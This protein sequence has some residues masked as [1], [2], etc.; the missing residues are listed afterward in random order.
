MASTQF[1]ALACK[2]CRANLQRKLKRKCTRELPACS[3]CVRL[4]K[5]CE[6]PL[7]PHRDDSSS[8]GSKTLA[9]RIQYL[10]QKFVQQEHAPTSNTQE[11]D[12]SFAGT[13]SATSNLPIPPWTSWAPPS[14]SRAFPE[15]YIL[16]S[17][18]FSKN[19]PEAL[20][21]GMPLPPDVV[22]TL[23]SSG[24]QKICDEYFSG[25]HSW[26]PV[27]IKKRINHQLQ[28]FD[29]S[30][31]ASLALLLLCMKLVAD[32]PLEAEKPSATPTYLL[33]REFWK[34]LENASVITLHLLQSVVLIALY[35]MGHGIFPAGY[36]TVGHA[37]RIGILMGLHDRR[38]A[39]QLF[40]QS[41]TWTLR[42][43]ERRT[44][45]AVIILDRFVHLGTS[46][47]PLATPEP[48]QGDL[49][50]CSDEGWME[51]EVGSNHPLFSSTFSANLD[52]GHFASTCQ[53]SH[54]LGRVLKHRDDASN[55]RDRPFR[56]SEAKQLHRTLVALDSDLVQRYFGTGFSLLNG[57]TGAVFE[58][59][60]L[61]CSARLIL[62]DM[63]G[64]NEP[65]QTASQQARLPEDTEMQQIALDG[66]KEIVT[67]RM[68]FLSQPLIMRT[69]LASPLVCHSLYHSASECAWFI[70]EN[71]ASDMISAMKTYVDLL[72]EI[73]KRWMIARH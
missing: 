38:N 34:A 50:P 39:A 26:L 25:T 43:E 72:M 33:A 35:E 29:S 59:F 27:L 69:D 51:G 48:G 68:S 28:S 22:D 42:E 32:G 47:L 14:R 31:N 10:E 12:V 17:D 49:L 18:S 24:I 45:W 44:W 41:E 56:L 62:Y 13:T 40:I 1:A 6:Y 61:C 73:G 9:E 67:Y 52:I 23:L 58:A 70:K 63:Y 7:Q 46:G 21:P 20:D 19:A 8:D 11:P 16:D 2:S 65:D 71:Q 54:I 66:I 36:L 3:L 30:N 53:A 4:E 60:A 57:D 55:R 37:A 15:L 5:N 64:C